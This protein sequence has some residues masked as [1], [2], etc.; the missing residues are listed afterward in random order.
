MTAGT[1]R[2]HSDN[3]SFDYG[4]QGIAERSGSLGLPTQRNYVELGVD[5][6][7]AGR[8]DDEKGE[9][10]RKE[11]VLEVNSSDSAGSFGAAKA[12]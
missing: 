3:D 12:Y 4:D 6:N 2:L 5:I 7:K 1:E 8:Y 10:Y 9:R 11:E